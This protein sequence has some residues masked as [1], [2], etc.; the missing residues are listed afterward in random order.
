[1]HA[2]ENQSHKVGEDED[3]TF[4]MNETSTTA[5]HERPED[6][7]SEKEKLDQLGKKEFR[8]LTEEEKHPK[9]HDTERIKEMNR[10]TAIDD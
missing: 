10:R 3:L 7:G 9:L 2:N 1:M 4:D 8:P 6:T 5:T